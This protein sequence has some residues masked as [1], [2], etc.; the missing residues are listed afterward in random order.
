MS[1]KK[2]LVV[3]DSP[4]QLKLMSD[5]LMSRGY[6]IVTARDGEEALDKVA[7]EKPDLVVLDVIMPKKNGFRVC[8]DIK[9]SPLYK[10]IKVILIS[11][12]DQESDKFWGERQGADLYITK[13]F[14][15]EELVT[16]V[17]RLLGEAA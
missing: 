13:P 11:S 17:A 12:K 3:D 7:S 8:R 15:D 10:D 9:I 16:G 2:V 4:T 6:E 5:P 14:T 1:N